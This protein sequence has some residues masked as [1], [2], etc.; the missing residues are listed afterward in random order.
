[1]ENQSKAN[2]D[3]VSQ[4]YQAQNDWF[5]IYLSPIDE[6]H[7]DRV[8]VVHELLG[9][10]PRSMLELGAGGGQTAVVLA[11]AGHE[12]TMIELLE[13]STQ[14][15]QE[16]A[17]NHQV[18][19]KVFQGDFYTIELSQT[20]EAVLYFDSFGIGSDA[21]QQ[22]L[23]QRVAAWLKPNGQAIIEIGTPWY[24]SGVAKGRTVDLGAC[25]RKYDFEVRTSRLIDC[26]WHKKTPEKVVQQSL[27]CYSPVDLELLLAGT[28]LELLQVRPN[29]SIAYEPTRWLK[30]VSLSDAMTYYA[31]LRKKD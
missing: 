26:W 20:F 9:E 28:N 2:M 6:Q 23:L 4:F 7:E 5:G 17:K 3:W 15:A 13:D 14:Y 19:L 16:L 24:W 18:S 29:N 31:L 8:V 25:F 27:R 30:N 10:R 12:I 22:R 1:M 21:D 11:Q